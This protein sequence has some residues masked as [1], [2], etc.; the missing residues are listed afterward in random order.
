MSSICG[1]FNRTG[2]PVSAEA[3]NAM[4]A[5]LGHW[6]REGDRSGAWRN[7]SSA[8]AFGH[9]MLTNTPESLDEILPFNHPASGLTITA[10]A[11]ID[12]REELCRQ[13]AIPPQERESIPD[14]LLILA[15]YRKWGKECVTRLIGDFAFAIWDEREKRLFCARDHLGNK[16]MFYFAADDAFIFATEM[17]GI[18]RVRN[19]PRTLDPDWIADALTILIADNKYTP[20]RAI[21]RLPPAHWLSVSP[22]EMKNERYWHPDPEKEIRLHSEDDY[23][24]ALR[25][26][27][28]EAVRCRVRSAFPVGAELSGGLDSS[29][30]AALAVR[31]AESRNLKFITFSHVRGEADQARAAYNDESEFQERLRRHAGISNSRSLTAQDRGVIEAVRNSL[32][33]QDGPTHRVYGVLTDALHEAAAQEGTRTLL[34]GFGGD[35]VVTHQ[36]G[37]YLDELA[38]RRAWQEIWREFRQCSAAGEQIPIRIFLSK[39]VEE[40]APLLKTACKRVRDILRE[41]GMNSPANQMESFPISPEFYQSAAIRQRMTNIPRLS[42]VGDVRS[43]QCLRITHAPVA[44]RLEA[45]SIEAAA[46]RLEYRCPLLD[47]RLVEFHLAAPAHLKRK[48]GYG[49]YLFRR[50]I[51]GVVPP[52][53]QWRTDKTGATIPSTRHRLIRDAKSIENLILRAKDTQAANYIDLVQMAKRLERIVNMETDTAAIRQGVFLNALK[54]ILYFE[55]NRQFTDLQL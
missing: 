10:D 48:N 26:K 53:I 47:I 7:T 41:T 32:Q 3:I 19:L 44:A 37:E 52:E 25:E 27:L 24:E 34:S 55:D 43:S 16:P 40:Y 42:R 22:G 33:V 54:L 2:K 49:R 28:T 12:N 50:A 20:Y 30:V 29:P 8:V 36:A 21:R 39:M 13:L 45:C 51:E 11:R 5:T 38:R 35:E 46:R 14:S 6:Q 31:H 1:I 23:V 18:F 17:K 15:S 4:I 9:L